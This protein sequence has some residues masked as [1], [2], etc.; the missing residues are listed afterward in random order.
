[1]L[2]KYT[3][4]RQVYQKSVNTQYGDKGPLVTCTICVVLL[5]CHAICVGKSHDFP[6]ANCWHLIT[7]G[8]KILRNARPCY[9]IISGFAWNP[10]VFV[11]FLPHYTLLRIYQ[12]GV[13]TR[14]CKAFW[15]GGCVAILARFLRMK[16]AWCC[17]L[18]CFASYKATLNHTS[19][20]GPAEN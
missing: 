17:H 8:D 1:M 6:F 15:Q 2:C 16:I 5:K 12:Q 14:W 10:R 11:H 3:I 7:F 19:S 13:G 20:T 4:W 9:H 18:R